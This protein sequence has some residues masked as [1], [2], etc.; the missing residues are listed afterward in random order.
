MQ[1]IIYLCIFARRIC[2]LMNRY[3]II[4]ALFVAHHAVGE[5]QV[6]YGDVNHDQKVNVADIVELTDVILTQKDPEEVTASD[7]PSSSS[8]SSESSA[9][10]RIFSSVRKGQKVFDATGKATIFE[11][12]GEGQIENFYFAGDNSSWHNPEESVLEV[13][14]DGELC[15]SGKLYE[16]A[17][18]STDIATKTY[19]NSIQFE[20]PLF[21]KFGSLNTINLD[22]KIPYYESCKVVL[23]QAAAGVTDK[24][25][26]TVRARNVVNIEYGGLRMPYGAYFK[27]IRTDNE[28]IAAGEQYTLMT[29]SK[30]SMLIGMNLFLNC[31]KTASLEGCFRAFN[32]TTGE[33]T[34][35]SSGLEDFLLGTYYFESGDT[36]QGQTVG[37]TYLSLASG[38]QISAYRMFVN[39]PI[40]FDYPVKLTVRNGESDIKDETTEASS[41]LLYATSDMTAGCICFFYEWN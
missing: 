7:L 17:A 36:F 6:Y 8:S 28:T 41:T 33:F 4:F 25:W 32:M 9:I 15:L 16:L 18:M 21:S 38:C 30:N 12:T 40:S 13:Y 5:A 35:L 19:Y 23:K 24:V 34:Y 37:Y 10:G 39:N 29:S 26:A 20:C 11:A 31:E 2:I 27:A 22:F 1:I 3:L 14:C